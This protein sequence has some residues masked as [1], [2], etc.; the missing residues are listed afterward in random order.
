MGDEEGVRSAQ[1]LDMDAIPSNSWIENDSV[2]YM[3]AGEE[4]SLQINHP[5]ER[6]VNVG[7]PELI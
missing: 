2:V 3:L 1:R 4:G 7:V 6:C 5:C